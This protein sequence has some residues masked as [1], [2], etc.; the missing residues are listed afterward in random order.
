MGQI[1]QPKYDNDTITLGYLKKYLNQ[2]GIDEKTNIAIIPKNYSSPPVPPYYQ[3]SLLVSD[4]KIYRCNKDRLVGIFSWD[5]WVLIINNE[6]LDNFIET[7]YKTDKLQ[8]EKQLDNKIETYYQE[9]DPSLNWPTSL[10]KEKHVGDYWYNTVNDTQWRYNKITTTTPITY[11][12]AQVNIPSTVYDLIDSKKSIYTSK[13]IS[14]NKDD[15]WV[16]EDTLAAEDLPIGTLENPIKKGDWVFSLADSETYDKSHW[17]KKDEKVDVEYL[18][19]HYYTTG[20]VDQKFEVVNSNITSEITKS[21]EDIMLE[22]SSDYT[23]KETFTT[24][25]NDYDQQIEEINETITTTTEDVSALTV[26]KNR[27]N[28]VVSSIEE[29]V[30]T[31]SES[32]LSNS[33]EIV[34]TKEKISSTTQTV[35]DLNIS[36]QETQ[37]SIETVVGEVSSLS[38]QI[39]DMSYNFST[40]GLAIG[41]TQDSNN[42]LFNNK[43]IKVYNYNTLNAIFNN[44]GSG[45]DK[46]IVTGTAQIGYL[47]FVKSTKNGEPV[48]KIFHLNKVIEDL[49]DLEVE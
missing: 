44:K 21:K 17:I 30:A 8:I 37:K 38:G 29:T 7:V 9:N 33:E 20:T 46:L 24:A 32:I 13:P 15:M 4:N 48:T 39:T 27:I 41:T 5:D 14:Y 18:N 10:E 2:K 28:Q 42:S 3:N 45:I 19:N 35:N 1:M 25:I 11:K 6:E 23:T 22:V 36:F 31:Q 16:I 26:E 40:K 43:G 47:R 12:W 34:E 49:E